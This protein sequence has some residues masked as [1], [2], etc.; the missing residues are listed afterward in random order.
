MEARG[1]NKTRQENEREPIQHFILGVRCKG[2][3][4]NLKTDQLNRIELNYF[5]KN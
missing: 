3:A 5:I 1:G 4:V 2:V